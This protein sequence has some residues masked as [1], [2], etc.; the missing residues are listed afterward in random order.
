MWYYV[1]FFSCVYLFVVV[2]GRQ[3]LCRLMTISILR[4]FGRLLALSVLFL[5]LF[6]SFVFLCIYPEYRYRIR[7]YVHN[8]ECLVSFSK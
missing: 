1:Y 6:G 3:A 2:V 8:T 7:I 4:L 5:Y